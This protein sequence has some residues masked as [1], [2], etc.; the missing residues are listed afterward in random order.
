MLLAAGL[1]A[2]SA[3]HGSK[4]AAGNDPAAANLAGPAAA[5]IVTTP[6]G[7][8]VETLAPG[9]GPHPRVGDRVMVAY[10][11]HLSNGTLFDSSARPVAMT[12]GELVPGFNE[13][14][15]LMQKGGRYR[16]FIPAALGYGADGAGGGTIP[17]NADLTFIVTLVDLTPANG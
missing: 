10:E 5:N 17:P 7:V 16:L 6:S 8:A 15:T 11:G 13:G 14:L 2:L 1:L 9:S 12:V 3:C 4:T